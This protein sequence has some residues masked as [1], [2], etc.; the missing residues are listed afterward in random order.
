MSQSRRMSGVNRTS[1]RTSFGKAEAE[2]DFSDLA[3]VT[4]MTGIGGTGGGGSA[5]TRATTTWTRLLDRFY[6]N[7]IYTYIWFFYHKRLV[8]Y[9]KASQGGGG[10]GAG[11]GGG[12]AGQSTKPEDQ[13]EQINQHNV[14]E[15]IDVQWLLRSRS[16]WR[17]HLP[18]M[19]ILLMDI[20]SLGVIIMHSVLQNPLDYISA[21]HMYMFLGSPFHLLN[22]TT[23]Q[24]EVM[25]L[26]WGVNLLVQYFLVVHNRKT[27]RLFLKVNFLV[28][29]IVFYDETELRR[30]GALLGTERILKYPM[31]NDPMIRLMRNVR[32]DRFRSI[33]RFFMASLYLFNYAMAGNVT[34]TTLMIAYYDFWD[35]PL[36]CVYVLLVWTPIWTIYTYY[37]AIYAY[38]VFFYFIVFTC[39]FRNAMESIR[40]T[41]MSKVVS[42]RSDYERSNLTSLNSWKSA[43]QFRTMY[44]LMELYNQIVRVL[45]SYMKLWSRYITFVLVIFNGLVCFN[46]YLYFY[47]D[48]TYYI[49]MVYNATSVTA[50]NI[51]FCSNF[52]AAKIVVAN[53][54]INRPLFSMFARKLIGRQRFTVSL[55]V[56]RI[57][58]IS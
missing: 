18:I 58:I 33:A 14:I 51:F 23:I 31:V 39:L 13:P 55:F 42:G 50:F 16:A 6:S 52:F 1:V 40:G 38:Y 36:P 7:L 22:S 20:R 10:V 32:L 11:G 9:T 29:L 49:K 43:V 5:V 57:I 24:S 3:A 53:V 15:N 30:R 2:V 44:N 47:T 25:A 12:Q 19:L 56:V 46:F 37:C 26:C 35:S 41:L 54:A 17:I 34:F 28:N 4:M 8:R 21:E 45:K 27:S 48:S